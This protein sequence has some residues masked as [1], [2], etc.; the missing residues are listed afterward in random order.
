MWV[1]YIFDMMG[2]MAGIKEHKIKQL[3]KIDKES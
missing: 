1:N 2:K 3:D